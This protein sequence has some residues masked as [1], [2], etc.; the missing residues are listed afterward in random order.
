MKI[1]ANQT[2]RLSSL[3]LQLSLAFDLNQPKFASRMLRQNQDFSEQVQNLTF[4][5]FSIENVFLGFNSIS[6]NG[7]YS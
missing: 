7:D 3:K 1:L 5:Q 4:D 2:Q 6:Q